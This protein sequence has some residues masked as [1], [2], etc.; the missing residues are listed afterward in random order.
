[1]AR[2]GAMALM[3]AA[4]AARLGGPRNDTIAAPVGLD[5]DLFG[6][7]GAD[8]VAGASGADRLFGQAGNDVLS[9]GAGADTLV[10]AAGDDSLAGGDGDDRLLGGLDAD[11]LDGGAGSDTLIGGAGADLFLFGPGG[12][13]D[14]AIADAED[15]VVVDAGT[16]SLRVAALRDDLFRFTLLDAAGGVTGTVVLRAEKL[17]A[18]ELRA[19]G[20]IIVESLP[21]TGTLPGGGVVISVPITPDG[22]PGGVFLRGDV[23]LGGGAITLPGGSLQTAGVAGGGTPPLTLA[24]DVFPG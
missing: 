20:F 19:G 12:G 10:G 11:T 7:A 6:G 2:D 5:A 3:M 1:M 16:G 15:S 22:G 24:D 14:M 13:Q 8:S 4:R 17:A 21:E 23:A 9:G 18:I